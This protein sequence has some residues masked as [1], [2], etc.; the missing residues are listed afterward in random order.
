M[1]YSRFS[2]VR[3]NIYLPDIKERNMR[4]SRIFR[5]A[6]ASIITVTFC[7]LSA[8]VAPA[9]ATLIDTADILTAQENDMARQKVAQ[10]LN[11]QDVAQHLQALG[12]DREEARARVATMTADEINLLVNKIDQLPAGGDVVS[13][14]IGAAVIAFV[15]LVVTDIMGLTDVFTFIKK[16]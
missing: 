8:I 1:S 2:L 9:H 16:R 7:F 15:V 4:R 11:R 13:L 10:F 12:V 3:P 14:L 5:K 6:V